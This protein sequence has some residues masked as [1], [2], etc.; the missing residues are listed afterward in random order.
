MRELSLFFFNKSQQCH[1]QSNQANVPPHW[2]VSMEIGTETRD[3]SL[4]AFMHC[5]A[6]ATA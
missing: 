3:L 6:A 4:H 5:A 2:E 1:G